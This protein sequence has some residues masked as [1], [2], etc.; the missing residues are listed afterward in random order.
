MRHRIAA[1]ASAVMAHLVA[2]SA[3]YG[4]A[5]YP[6][7]YCLLSERLDEPVLAHGRRVGYARPDRGPR[8]LEVPRTRLGSGARESVRR[9]APADRDPAPGAA[10]TADASRPT[11]HAPML[12]RCRRWMR[13]HVAELWSSARR[14]CEARRAMAEWDRLDERTLRDI[15][16]RR[17]ELRHFRDPRRC[18]G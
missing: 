15:G 11:A 12:A 8:R 10:A 4:A 1:A 13:S 2:G 3:A 9:V 6:E 14:A 17:Y 7:F 18:E 16:I 5:M